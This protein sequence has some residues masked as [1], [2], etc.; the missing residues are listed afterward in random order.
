MHGGEGGGFSVAR[1]TKEVRVGELVNL[2]GDNLTP[3]AGGADGKARRAEGHTQELLVEVLA[4]KSSLAVGA[5]DTLTPG[6]GVFLRLSARE[7]MLR[8]GV[9]LV[10]G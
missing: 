10:R 3:Q 7:R 6:G 5:G 2:V 4:G 9:V 8:H 1:H